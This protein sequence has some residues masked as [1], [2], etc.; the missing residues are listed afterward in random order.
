ML[1][2]SRWMRVCNAMISS[3]IILG[4]QYFLIL[5][6][7]FPLHVQLLNFMIL[8]MRRYIVLPVHVFCFMC[9]EKLVIYALLSVHYRMRISLIS[10]KLLVKTGLNHREESGSASMYFTSCFPIWGFGSIIVLSLEG[11]CDVI[12][13]VLQLV[14]RN[15]NTSSR[16]CGKGVLQDLRSLG[17]LACLS[18]MNFL[19]LAISPWLVNYSYVCLLPAGMISSSSTRKGLVSCMKKK[20]ATSWW[21]FDSLFFVTCS[22]IGS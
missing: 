22:S 15:L 1:L 9:V 7:F 19:R 3:F 2:N 21:V 13:L 4:L 18:C 11:E 17:F 20:C 8:M 16:H 6:L 5:F 10:R 12:I 14:I